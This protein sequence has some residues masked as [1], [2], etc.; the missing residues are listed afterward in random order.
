MNENV[1]TGIEQ[2]LRKRDACTCWDEAGRLD[3]WSQW[4]MRI[5]YMLLYLFL[6]E[7]AMAQMTI[8]QYLQTIT[9][10][11]DS[12][13]SIKREF[14]ATIDSNGNHIKEI[15]GYSVEKRF[16][17]N[18][19]LHEEYFTDGEH[20]IGPYQSYYEN[21]NIDEFYFCD[22]GNRVGY[23]MEFYDNKNKKIFGEYAAPANIPD[24][25]VVE[26]T[27]KRDPRYS[28]GGILVVKHDVFN[29]VKNGKWY[30][31]DKDGRLVKTEI[32]DKGK[33]VTVE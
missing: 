15:A 14:S 24:Y 26:D 17:K 1:I 7:T 25:Y 13:K 28:Y 27:L 10:Q 6:S 22:K 9:Y 16:Y 20:C 29:N 18:G 12:S 31:W 23:Y 19:N 3:Q 21:G 33:L 8:A 32:W 11:Y 2:G 30:Y 4:G 5:V